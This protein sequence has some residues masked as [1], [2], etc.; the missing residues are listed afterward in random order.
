MKII[1]FADLHLGVE[2]YGHIDP[3]TG[4]SSRLMDFLAT[5]DEMVDYALGNKIDLV[6]FCGDAYKTR[7]PTQTQQREFARRINRLALSGIPVFLLTGN[8][9]LP[10]TTGRATATEIF[11]TLAVKNVTVASKPDIYKIETRSGPCQVVALPWLRRSA[12]LARDD[13]KNLDMEQMTAKMQEA[14]TQVISAKGAALDPCLPAIL[15]AHV[16]VG[17]AT[18]GRGSEKLMSLGHE[19]A[20]LLG[21]VALPCFDYVALGHI[22][23]R[24]VLHE[25]PPVVYSGSMERIDFGEE[26]DDKGFYVIELD[27]EK[28]AGSR[29]VSY[30]FHS[31]KS[32]RFLT[33]TVEL[34]PDEA[35]PSRAI[36][37][38]VAREKEKARN[39]IVHVNISIPEQLQSQTNFREI[40]DELKDAYHL[41]IVPKILKETRVR[42]GS[43]PAEDVSPIE[44]LKAWMETQNIPAERRKTLLEYGEKLI[45]NRESGS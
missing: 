6:L 9:D 22:H 11:D 12:L 42:I 10:N 19:P 7:E 16:L 33:L 29:L 41:D 15:S 2:T 44:A 13:M 34:S 23:K 21:N 26:K 3:D 32:R 4:L 8:H 14:L 17:D 37:T 43:R 31:V 20:L 24:Q 45:D 38:A 27:P 18:V 35:N 39:A 1:H 28:P 25:H 36:L 30:E 5:F 40:R